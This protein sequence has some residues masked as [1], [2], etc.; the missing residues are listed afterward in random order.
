MK[1]AELRAVG[2][3][4]ITLEAS[5]SS[6]A[7]NPR[8]AL[9]CLPRRFGLVSLKISPFLLQLIWLGL[10]PTQGGS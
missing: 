5:R 10:C 4:S 3:P 7:C 6:R 2:D 9:K 8:H 1:T